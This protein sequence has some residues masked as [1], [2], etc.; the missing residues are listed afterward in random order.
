[1]ASKWDDRLEKAAGAR[2]TVTFNCTEGEK[3][4]IAS[5]AQAVG[6][7]HGLRPQLDRNPASGMRVG[8]RAE[9]DGTD[10]PTA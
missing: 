7:R 3:D 1:M 9:G 4:E 6:A 5:A 8:Y 2:G 10:T